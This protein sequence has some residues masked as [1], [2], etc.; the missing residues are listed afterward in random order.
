MDKIHSDDFESFFDLLIPCNGIL[1]L[2]S[3]DR[4]GRLLNLAKLCHHYKKY[5]CAFVEYGVGSRTCFSVLKVFSENKCD[6]W[7][8]DA[9]RD[10]TGSGSNTDTHVGLDCSP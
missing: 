6:V 1:E 4:L 8:F 9:V 5:K 3:N 10:V 2:N 7:G